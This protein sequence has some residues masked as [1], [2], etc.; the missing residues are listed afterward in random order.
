MNV[1]LATLQCGVDVLY[2][3][4]DIVL[5]RDPFSFLQSYNNVDLLAQKDGTICTGFMFLHPTHNAM[6]LIDVA[7]R[8]RGLVNGGDQRAVLEAVRYMRHVR[9][10]LLPAS[11]FMSGE[12]F[13]S[14]HEYY[15]DR[16]CRLSE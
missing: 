8:I 12:V 14:N 3:D 1:L 11:L 7:R 4:S 2:M 13:F 5:L 16:I 6:Q 15:W 9:S 10:R